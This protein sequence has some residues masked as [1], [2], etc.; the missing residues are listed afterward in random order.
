MF[1]LFFAKDRL[2]INIVQ[3][4]A[5]RNLINSKFFLLSNYYLIAIILVFRSIKILGDTKN[6]YNEFGLYL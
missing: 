4:K 5:S 1:I 3:N 2:K 6:N